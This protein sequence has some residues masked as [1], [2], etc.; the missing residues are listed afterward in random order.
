[1]GKSL[2]IKIVGDA[3]GYARELGKAEK[4]TES[5]GSKLKGMGKAG[6]VAAGAAGLALVTK[7]LMDSVGAAREAEKA[8]ARLE[9]ALK[10]ANISYA[11]HGKAI[12][13]AIQKT[14]R[15]A[16]LDDEDLSD[17][18]AKLVRTTGDVT[19]ATD[20]MN[21]AADIARARNIS[22]ETATKAVEKAYLG[23]DAALK[24]FGVSVPKVSDATDQ[25]KERIKGLQE[26][27]QGATGAT[28]EALLAQIE[29]AKG[30]MKAAKEADKQATSMNALEKATKQF[31]GSAEAY[32]KTS[33]GAQE[34]FQV[35]IENLQESI[36]KKLLPV[37]A[38]LTEKAT[39]VVTWLEKNGP[40]IGEVFKKVA[41]VVEAALKP[42]INLIE[43]VLKIV[44]DV[45]K[46]VKAIID[47]DWGKAWD[48]FSDIPKRVIDIVTGTFLALPKML[49][50]AALSVGRSIAEKIGEGLQALPGKL[51]DALGLAAQGLT[52]LPGV[53][54]SA[55]RAIGGKILD[56]IGEG[57]SGTIGGLGDLGGK[58]AGLLGGIGEAGSAA[59]NA[60]KAVGG[61]V[62]GAIGD[63]LSGTIGG[64]GDLGGKIAG[65]LGG[66][67]EAG[68]AVW[69]A[70]KGAG[71]RILDG[72]VA[73]IRAYVGV[74]NA[75]ADRISNAVSAIAGD[76]LGAGRN[77]AEKIKDGLSAT[78]GFGTALFGLLKRGAENVAGDVI[79][80]GKKLAGWVKQ[81]VSS[82]GDLLSGA[83]VSA[84][85]RAIDLLNA[86]IRAYNAIPLAPNIPQ[87]PKVGGGSTS[88]SGGSSAGVNP[89]G[90]NPRSPTSVSEPAP[91]L[92]A[93]QGAPAPV[94]NVP[95]SPGTQAA[96]QGRPQVG[97]PQP[98]AEGGIVTRPVV[99]L[100][101]EAGPEAVMPI[102]KLPGL[103]RG[104]GGWPGRQLVLQLHVHGSLI[105]ERELGRVI[106]EALLD[107]RRTSPGLG[108]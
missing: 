17:A 42:T 25:L 55:A 75:I 48:A 68:S 84:V 66:I 34:R 81:G 49:G 80:L 15:L 67:G 77:I 36:G 40:T 10:S 11:K 2:V 26:K 98:F 32:G 23:S 12:D 99:G 87:I 35:A 72:I 71:G 1:M 73:A 22:L 96:L 74:G 24:K 8:Q 21:L 59:F 52:Q 44:G 14:S 6:A 47:G 62:L 63:G 100:L 97:G 106:Q 102:E 91:V 16:A 33:A 70:A 4:G 28:K 7:G 79:G 18:Y 41:A 3:S 90:Q 51:L 58:I 60:A 30:H 101:G 64:L 69:N 45:V 103:M 83:F 88:S 50:E 57:L 82:V 39:E 19:K 29:A 89:P 43:N 56:A 104:R 105:H 78:V 20:G 9:G 27:L 92:R 86:A 107:L 108:F 54:A 53:L 85:N 46:G 65:L 95:P 5:F 94:S 37:L 76:L 93:T 13:A 31:A 61:R 38:K